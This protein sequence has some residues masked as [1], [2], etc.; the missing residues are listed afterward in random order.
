MQLR[1]LEAAVGDAVR[2]RTGRRGGEK[3][4]RGEG[5]EKDL[6]TQQLTRTRQMR[7][8]MWG[9]RGRGMHWLSLSE[10]DAPNIHGAPPSAPFLA[11]V[12]G[13]F[14]RTSPVNFTFLE[15]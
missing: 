13:S 6:Q 14:R 1:Q 15:G 11:G 7:G 5:E 3:G 8:V 10:S 4:K 9:G 12:L 2:L